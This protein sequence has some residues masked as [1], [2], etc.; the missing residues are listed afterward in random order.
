MVSAKAANITLKLT[1]MRSFALSLAST[2]CG[3]QAGNTI[4]VPVLTLT[5]DLVGVVGS[6]L[7]DWRADD[8]GLRPRIVEVDGVRALLYLDVI[9]AAQEIVRVSVHP[10]ASARRIHEGRKQPYDLGGLAPGFLGLG[11]ARIV[12]TNDN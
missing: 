8:A 2:E 9:G 7:G 3:S 4:S 6:E 1:L 5:H 11:H 10:V 12:L